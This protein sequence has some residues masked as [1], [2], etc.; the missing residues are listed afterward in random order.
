MDIGATFEDCI[1]TVD[2]YLDDEYPYCDIEFS[3]KDEDY[4]KLELSQKTLIADNVNT[5]EYR[6]SIVKGFN[7]SLSAETHFYFTNKK[8]CLYCFM[9]ILRI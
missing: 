4:Q 9:L 5:D 3:T 1:C 7:N 2:F 6:H 8:C